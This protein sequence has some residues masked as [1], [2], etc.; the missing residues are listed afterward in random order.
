ML[1]SRNTSNKTY[2]SPFFDSVE[3]VNE[4]TVVW[5]A[6]CT[7]GPLKLAAPFNKPYTLSAKV[8]VC[9]QHL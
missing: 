1:F 4:S 5:R 8:E 3:T 9:I 2:G 7:I 6:L